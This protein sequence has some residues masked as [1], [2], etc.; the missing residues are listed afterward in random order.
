MTDQTRI[1]PADG[2]DI[3][4]TVRARMTFPE[5]TSPDL[6]DH[7]E[8]GAGKSVA[9]HLDRIPRRFRTA[10][11]SLLHRSQAPDL[12]RVWATDPAAETLILGGGVGTGKT[13][14]AA[15]TALDYLTERLARRLDGNPHFAWWSVASLLDALRPASPNCEGIWRVVKSAPL[16]VLD[17]LAH[18][19]V[20]D[21]ASERIWMLVNER[22][23]KQLRQVVTTN[24]TWDDLTDTWGASVMDRLREGAV[25]ADFTGKSLRKPWLR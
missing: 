10:R 1:P 8:Y 6:I 20:T 12:I 11:T 22:A 16:L 21:W 25:V 13:Y 5:G 4:A 7:Y 19:R 9:A 17:D 15:A 14:A 3:T 18:V 2:S 24:V 23:E